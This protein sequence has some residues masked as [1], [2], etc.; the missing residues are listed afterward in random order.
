M[1]SFSGFPSLQ[2][3]TLYNKVIERTLQLLCLKI[4][5]IL[6]ATDDLHLF[7]ED[8]AKEAHE[9]WLIHLKKCFKVIHKLEKSKSIEPK[10][11]I[12]LFPLVKFLKNRY[13]L[14]GSTT[15]TSFYSQSQ[16]GGP[17]KDY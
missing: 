16:Y 6:K 9:K 8:D 13:G 14:Y 17:I 3:E 7:K 4:V 5:N 1:A 2:Q 15:S 10:F 11:T 12:S